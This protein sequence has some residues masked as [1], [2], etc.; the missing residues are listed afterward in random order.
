MDAKRIRWLQ[1]HDKATGGIM[2]LLPLVRDMP[3][4]FTDTVDR[5]RRIFKNTRGRLIAWQLHPSEHAAIH[6]TPDRHLGKSII[7]SMLPTAVYVKVTNAT[8]P[9]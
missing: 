6:Q 1:R 4:Y 3:V 9:S 5:E 8:W 2:G 7:L